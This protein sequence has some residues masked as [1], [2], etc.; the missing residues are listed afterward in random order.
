MFFDQL[1]GLGARFA[2]VDS[3]AVKEPVIPSRLSFAWLWRRRIRYGQTHARLLRLRHV[4]VVQAFALAG[5]KATICLLGAAATL[6]SP[7]H[8]AHW[9]LRAAL[10]IGS[11]MGLAGS[12]DLD[13]Y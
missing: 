1:R 6:F 10:H 8:R 3:A 7:T 9:L 11:C 5:T 2:F 12:A 13:L 4:N